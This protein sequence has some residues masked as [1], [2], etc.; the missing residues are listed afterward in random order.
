MCN[1]DRDSRH[2]EEIVLPDSRFYLYMLAAVSAILAIGLVLHFWGAPKINAILERASDPRATPEE[3]T[4]GLAV[5]SALLLTLSI[6]VLGVGAY[7]VRRGLKILA[8]GRDPLPGEIRWAQTIVKRGRE[9][10]IRAWVQMAAGGLLI[11][12]GLGFA[13]LVAALWLVLA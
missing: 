4:A 9:A 7:A 11:A 12:G 1:G 10:R 2:D 13:G 3:L 5:M 6:M 8:V